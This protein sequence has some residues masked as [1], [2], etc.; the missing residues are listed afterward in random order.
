MNHMKKIALCMA[1][2]FAAVA[3]AVFGLRRADRG[4]PVLTPAVE[5]GARLP[6]GDGRYPVATV[7]TVPLRRG[8]LDEALTCYGRVI[9]M[10]GEMQAISVPF[11]GL[12]RA[13]FVTEG[14]SLGKGE[15]LLE[16]EPSPDTRLK[17]EQARNELEAAREAQKL[18]EARV[19]MKLAVDRD[20]VQAG[21]RLRMAQRR[22]E[23]MVKRGIDGPR[24]IRSEAAGIVDR[25][26]VQQG[27]IVPP[28]STLMQMIGRD[29]IAVR[30]GMEPEDIR[31]VREGQKVKVMQIGAGQVSP[32]TGRIRLIT[33][34]V[35]P[36]TRLVNVFIRPDSSEGLLLREY[37]T[38]KVTVASTEGW[39]VPRSAVLP[40][41]GG[42]SI[43]TV[44]EGR[45][46]KHSV[47]LGLEDREGAE[48]MDDSLVEG[49]PVV[50]T[51][52]YELAEGMA[53][54][55]APGH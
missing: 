48:V 43:F 38:A 1:I 45:A 49:M 41:D 4:Q 10:P 25:I 50:V 37:V 15:P 7:E 30:I 12:I 40:D 21:L 34:R 2:L 24:T 22:F 29:Q 19:K 55:E 3:A 16:I 17:L 18:T 8:R 35:N 20:R 36:E 6:T 39:V 5:K 14:Q 26:E 13:V 52:N 9:A 23:S 31:K 44:K 51:G 27:Q 32:M 11:E 33:R 46:V 54:T 53:V 47:A 28:G 42:Y